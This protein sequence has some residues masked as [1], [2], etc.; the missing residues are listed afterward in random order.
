M[1]LTIK[2]PSVDNGLNYK[3]AGNEMEEVDNEAEAECEFR[4]QKQAEENESEGEKKAQT[5]TTRPAGKRILVVAEEIQIRS[6]IYCQV[7]FRW[8]IGEKKQLFTEQW[9]K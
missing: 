9:F 4:R 5:E 6:F 2:S 1:E 8:R 7:S 3:I